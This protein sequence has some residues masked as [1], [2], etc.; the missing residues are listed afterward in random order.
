MQ[1]VNSPSVPDSQLQASVLSPSN[2]FQLYGSPSL[3]QKTV[4]PLQPHTR[5]SLTQRKS[6]S[7][8]VLSTVMLAGV[9]AVVKLFS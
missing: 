4:S 3:E 8:T 5:F 6:R 9:P 1:P 2:T 7:G